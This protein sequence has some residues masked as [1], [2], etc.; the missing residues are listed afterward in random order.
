[1]ATLNELVYRANPLVTRN[2][3]ILPFKVAA[4]VVPTAPMT[5]G[6]VDEKFGVNVAVTSSSPLI[7]ILNV[8]PDLVIAMCVHTP[9]ATGVTERSELAQFPEEKFISP[10]GPI[11]AV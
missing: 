7:N 11:A 1:M 9:E 6:V 4:T 10:V 3:S 5:N 8:D 2:S